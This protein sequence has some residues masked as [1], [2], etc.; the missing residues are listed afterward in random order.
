MFGISARKTI[1]ACI[2]PR[3]SNVVEKLNWNARWMA[4]VKSAHGVPRFRDRKELH[5]FVHQTY[6]GR[7]PI[8]YLEF[9]VYQGDSLRFWCGTNTDSDSRFYGFDSFE[10]LPEDWNPA[11]PKGAFSTGGKPPEIADARVRFVMGWFQEVLPAFL[12]SYNPRDC[13]LVIHCDSDLYSSALF[14]LTS[15]DRMIR[16]GTIVIFDEFDAVFDEYRALTDYAAAYLRNY[17]IVA[18]TEGFRQAAMEIA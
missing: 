4:T 17:R 1:A 12:A 6:C 13:P 16:P 10:G 5:A 14:C 9:G 2:L 3:Y 18:V 15:I 11:F 7:E 8:D